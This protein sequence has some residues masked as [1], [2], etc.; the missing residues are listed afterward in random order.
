MIDKIKHYSLTNPASVYDEEALTALELAG[1]TTAKVNECVGKV[2]EIDEDVTNRLNAQDKA[3]PVKVNEAIQKNVNDGT[4]EVVIEK[5]TAE[6]ENRLNNL[7]ENTPE[8]STTMDAEVIDIRVGVDGK[9]YGSAGEAV[10]EQLKDH[11]AYGA[12]KNKYN[13]HDPSIVTGEYYLYSNGSRQANAEFERVTIP[14]EGGKTYHINKTWTHICFY[15]KA[16]GAQANYISGLNNAS[17]FTTP[18]NAVCAV[19][20]YA[21]DYRDTLQIEEGEFETD[22]EAYSY[23]VRG[24]DLNLGSV[25]LEKLTSEARDQIGVKNTLT[26]T[27]DANGSGDFRSLRACFDYIEAQKD[28]YDSFEV[29]VMKGTYNVKN[30]YTSEEWSTDGFIG[31]M[32]PNNVHL[33]GYGCKKSEVVITAEN[34]SSDASTDISTLNIGDNVKIS[35]VTVKGKYLRYVIHDDFSDYASANKKGN[36]REIVNVEFIGEQMTMGA[37][38]GAGTKGGA[39]W[40]F[41]NVRFIN[42][43]SEIAFSV[44][45]KATAPA[46]TLDEEIR[47]ECC[48]FIGN[49]EHNVRISPAVG[50]VDQNVIFNGC[51]FNGL[52]ISSQYTGDATT[53]YNITGSGNTPDHVVSYYNEVDKLSEPHFADRVSQYDGS[54]VIS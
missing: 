43:T 34:S 18:V 29:R 10:R 49:G 42:K 24:E 32:I 50:G 47:F 26:I 38:Y 13:K 16:G 5:H 22:Y 39:K 7:I 37:T 31:L 33:R 17:T 51:T 44:H 45:D 27:V 4:F 9:T 2:N 46:S 3:I 8:G 41:K 11:V 52:L 35:N 28:L 12:G 25:G 48:E 14:I 40:T 30:D 54:V 1:R 53:V 15:S 6:L 20:S 21:I 36:V 19:V 23:G